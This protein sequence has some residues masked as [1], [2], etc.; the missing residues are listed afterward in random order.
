MILQKDPLAFLAIS[1]NVSEG[2]RSFLIDATTAKQ[3]MNILKSKFASKSIPTQIQTIKEV[4]SFSF[5]SDDFQN[6]FTKLRD[7][8]RT[9]KAANEDTINLST[10]VALIALS[11]L[12]SEFSSIRTVLENAAT[13][14]LIQHFSS[15][16]NW[17]LS[18]SSKKVHN[19]PNSRIQPWPRKQT[20]RNKNVSTI[21]I[22]PLAGHVTLG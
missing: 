9:F 6:G 7:L 20:R 5:V 22:L 15:L 14:H 11:A 3:C 2:V 12:P 1:S 10:L 19:I 8:I 13:T 4:C 16:T 21:E 17:N 18:F